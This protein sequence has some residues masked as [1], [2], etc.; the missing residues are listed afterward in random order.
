ME[1]ELADSKEI[2]EAIHDRQ[3]SDSEF[4]KALEYRLWLQNLKNQI[5][6]MEYIKDNS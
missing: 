4:I 1:K 6:I 3:G 2:L 5:A